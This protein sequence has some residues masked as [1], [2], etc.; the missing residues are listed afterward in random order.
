MAIRNLFIVVM[1]LFVVIVILFSRCKGTNISWHIK[2]IFP[3]FK[4][5]NPYLPIG[6]FMSGGAA[7][8]PQ[9]AENGMTGTFITQSE[10]IR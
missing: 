7:A 4:G 8:K 5:E 2:R 1:F 10:L 9:L 6:A 3:I